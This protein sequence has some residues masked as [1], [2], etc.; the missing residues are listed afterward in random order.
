MDSTAALPITNVAVPLDDGVAP[1]ELGVA[2]ELFGLD[3]SAQE[4]PVYDFALCAVDHRAVRTTGGFVIQVEH[5]LD[6]LDGADLVVL[7]AGSWVQRPPAPALVSALR[8]A[9]ERGAHIMAIC[10]GAFVLAATGLLDGRAATT[11]WR[12]TDEF[13]RRFPAV[14]VR[15][16]ALYV[17]TGS[18]STSA[19]TA[20]GIDLGLHLIRRAHGS[21]VATEVARRMVVPPHRSGDQAQYILRPVP[22]TSA[23]DVVGRAQEWAQERLGEPLTVDDWARS[24]HVAP[25]TFAR[26]FRDATGTTPGRWLLDQR[27]ARARELLETS[28]ATV[29]HIAHFVGL[30]S[31]DALQRHFR[32][33]LGTTPSHYR[34]AFADKRG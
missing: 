34:Q 22:C 1:F 19:G 32:Q 33:K 16:G 26:L 3:R 11:H 31:P 24:V 12:W 18:V 7:V 5:G 15:P 25:R 6:R 13:A 20:A 17:D 30:G 21:S 14:E 9:H 23:D 27:V 4:L 29:A 10:R 28:T 2:C 8:A